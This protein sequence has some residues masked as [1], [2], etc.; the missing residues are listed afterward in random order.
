M[1]PEPRSTELSS[2]QREELL[3]GH[4]R[5]NTASP[6]QIPGHPRRTGSKIALLALALA[7]FLVYFDEAIISTAIPK[8][9]DDFNS[10]SDIGWYGSAYM[11]F[12][13]SFQ[14]QFGRLY[15]FFPMDRVFLASTALFELGV[16]ICGISP[17]SAIFIVGRAISGW[18]ASGISSGTLIILSHLV[19][20]NKMPSYVG[21]L[22][23]I[24][25]IAAA[26]GPVVAGLLTDSPLTWRWYVI[27]SIFGPGEP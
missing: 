21:G 14:L 10:L 5:S 17:S 16:L 12:Q 13:C 23:A 6:I 27:P 1:E 9:T 25:G 20:P 8:I 2:E 18:G 11:L 19:P 22:G 24:Y 26:I 7:S 3:A 15:A 4:D